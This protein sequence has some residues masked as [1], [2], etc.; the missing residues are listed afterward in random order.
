MPNLFPLLRAIIDEDRSPGRFIL[1]GST[2]PTLLRS[3]SESLAARV[4][5]LE[6]QPFNLLETGIS[7]LNTL[8]QRGGFPQ[9]FLGKLDQASFDW[10]NQLIRSYIERDLPLLGLNAGKSTL[11]NLIKMLAGGTSQIWNATLYSKSLGLTSPTVKYLDYLENSFLIDTL[12]PFHFHIKKRLVKSP[13]VYFKD[14]GLL[15]AILFIPNFESLQG[16]LMVGA[17]WENFIIQQVKGSFHGEFDFYRTHEGTEADLII[18]KGGI[19]KVLLEIKYTNAPKISK[20]M[21]IAI[22]DLGTDQNFI[23]I[24]G[25]DTY[26]V[27]K[28]IQVMNLPNFIGQIDSFMK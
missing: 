2:S 6:L 21:L 19:P 27:H 18:L 28:R 16:N 11:T 26:P 3:S 23:I 5:Y 9:S 24:P 13:K 17:S 15:H 22:E 7:S 8:W 1:L 20:G 25:S 4:A 12:Q 14:T 10:R